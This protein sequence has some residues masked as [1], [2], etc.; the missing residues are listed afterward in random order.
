MANQTHSSGAVEVWRGAIDGLRINRTIHAGIWAIR[1]P[2]SCAATK[3]GSTR[4]SKRLYMIVDAEH[5]VVY[6]QKKL[7]TKDR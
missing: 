3:I 7:E 6:D 1:E 2:T 5:G 4:Q